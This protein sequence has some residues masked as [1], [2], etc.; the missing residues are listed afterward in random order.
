MFIPESDEP[1]GP[2]SLASPNRC[3]GGYGLHLYCKYS[4][5]AHGFDE[6]PHQIGEYETGA[7]ARADAKRKGWIL[8][9]DGYG[10]CPKCAKWMRE[11]RQCTS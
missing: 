2:R 9:R 8:H 10:T 11:N 5:S 7:Q 4:N 6:F 1:E 3:V